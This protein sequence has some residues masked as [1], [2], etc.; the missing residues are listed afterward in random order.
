MGFAMENNQNNSNG[1]KQLE[2]SLP[3]SWYS[4]PSHHRKEEAHIWQADWVYLCHGSALAKPRQYQTLTIGN[5]PVVVVRDEDGMLRGY[6]NTC[7]HRGSALCLAQSGRLDANALVCPYHQWSF[8]L[9]DGSLAATTSFTEPEGFNKSDYPL[10]PIAVQEWRGAIFVNLDPNA[11]WDVDSLFQRSANGLSRFPLEE[12]KV[13]KTWSKMINCNWKLF[14][15][16]FNE[17]LH[18]PNIHPELAAL[19][20]LYSRRIINKMDVPDWE[21]HEDSNDPL[22]RGG[23]RSGAETWSKDGSAQGHVISSLSHEEITRGQLYASAWPSMFIAGYADHVRIVRVLPKGTTQTEITAEWLFEE[24]TLNNPQYDMAN[25]VD[26]ATLVMDQDGEA[27]EMNQLGLNA[28]PF[29]EGVL[30]PEEYL[31]KRFHDWVRDKLN[32]A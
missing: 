5:Q 24:Q 25:V 12:M 19:V 2:M 4:D 21:D 11:A 23:L 27:C 26:F 15:E 7:R 6:Y 14:W 1:L 22:Y 20:P 29:T 18:C 31:L 17:C 13:G 16:N 3:S 8:R 28:Q 9:N 30:M 32:S 10:F